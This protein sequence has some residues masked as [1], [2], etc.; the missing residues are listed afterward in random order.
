MKDL[1][2]LSPSEG[3]PDEFREA[4]ENAEDVYTTALSFIVDE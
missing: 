4:L 3:S 2:S 1:L